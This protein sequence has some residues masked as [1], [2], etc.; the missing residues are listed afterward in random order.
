MSLAGACL[1]GDYRRGVGEESE[2]VAVGVDDG[3]EAFQWR[4]R[5]VPGPQPGRDDIRADVTRTATARRRRNGRGV[6]PGSGDD[7]GLR[8]GLPSSVRRPRRPR[9][10]LPRGK[11]SVPADQFCHTPTGLRRQRLQAR[12]RRSRERGPIRD[13]AL[14]LLGSGRVSVCPVIHLDDLGVRLRATARSRGASL[15]G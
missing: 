6:L 2:G 12:T 10:P 13:A 5:S 3:A 8:R 15:P 14:R 9:R 11:I 1:S 7:R 4:G